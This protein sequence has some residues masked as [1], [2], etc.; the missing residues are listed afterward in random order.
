MSH[1]FHFFMIKGHGNNINNDNNNNNN[2]NDNNINI[3]QFRVGAERWR[4]AGNSCASG[5]GRD[6]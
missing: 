5:S 3:L 1:S 2:N 6:L 4:P